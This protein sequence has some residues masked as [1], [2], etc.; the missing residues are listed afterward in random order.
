MFSKEQLDDIYVHRNSTLT[1]AKYRALKANGYD[2]TDIDKKEKARRRIITE[3]NENNIHFKETVFNIDNAHEVLQRVKMSDK[4][5]DKFIEGIK[6]GN[7]DKYDG[8]HIQFDDNVFEFKEE[9]GLTDIFEYG[10]G[11]VKIFGF[12][13]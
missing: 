2:L 3:R 6:N 13:L 4:D 1:I 5:I 12:D 10:N 11:L 8:E 9:N 7:F